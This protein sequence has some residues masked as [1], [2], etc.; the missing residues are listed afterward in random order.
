MWDEYCHEVQHGPTGALADAWD[1]VLAPT[2]ASVVEPLPREEA[3]LLTI[4][5]AWDLDE[6][7]TD[8]ANLYMYL[9]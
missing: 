2:I 7:E 6:F 1:D 4:G 5:A 9:R 8:Q 3:V